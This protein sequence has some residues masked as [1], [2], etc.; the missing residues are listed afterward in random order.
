MSATAVRQLLEIR[1]GR[2]HR[3][4][5]LTES[6]YRIGR[7]E[8]NEVCLRA[9]RV[10]RFHARL[11]WTGVSYEVFDLN[12]SNNVRVNGERV[13][14]RLLR[15][16]DLLELSDMVEFLYIQEG[17]PEEHTQRLLA[18]FLEGLDIRH[19]TSIEA[20]GRSITESEEL[21]PTLEKI[22]RAVMQTVEADR[23]FVALV[24]DEGH[25]RFAEA[26]TIGIDLSR[27]EEPGDDPA[28]SHTTVERALAERDVYVIERDPTVESDSEGAEFP[29]S[30]LKLDLRRAVAS[31]LL[32]GESLVGVLYLDA[33][34]IGTTFG[35]LERRVF[36]IL[37]DQA[38]IA[39]CSSGIFLD[40]VRTK[41]GLEKSVAEHS[42]RIVEA[43]EMYGI[44][45]KH[46]AQGIFIAQGEE[47]LFANEAL[48]SLLG[49]EV[50]AVEDI[51]GRIDAEQ[52]SMVR[53]TLYG[54]GTDH[55]G[56]DV[57]VELRLEPPGRDGENGDKRWIEL[58]V[59]PVSLRGRSALQGTMIDITERRML[60]ERLFHTQRMEALG[61]L[62]GGIAHEFNNLLMMIQGSADI[63][64]HGMA[65]TDD[66]ELLHEIQK[67]CGR[68]KDLTARLLI[69]GRRKLGVRRPT[70]LKACI[71]ETVAL[72]ERTAPKSVL[73]SAKSCKEQVV[74]EV[75]RGRICQSLLNLG[76]NA[77]D[78]MEPGGCL[79]FEVSVGPLP[80]QVMRRFPRLSHGDYAR[81]VVRDTGAGMD[82]RTLGQVFDPFFT[83][84]GP[85]RGTGL[86]LAMVY[87]AM[88][89]C[90]GA[91]EVDSAMGTGTAVTLY[92]PL[93]KE[94]EFDEARAVKV[95]Q[96][97]GSE[98]IL[99]VD[100]EPMVRRTVRGLLSA[101]NY[102]VESA[103]SGAEA[104]QRLD[105]SGEAFDVVVLDVSMPD[106]DG[107]ECM[108][109]MRKKLPSV[110]ILLMSGH[111]LSLDT[112]NAAGA[113]VPEFLLK[114]FD[115]KTLLRSVRTLLRR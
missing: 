47:V 27:A 9:K 103:A 61:T 102:R 79:E 8:E 29:S 59:Q 44:L 1:D 95:P 22:L 57:R 52:Q 100:D 94:Q 114:P 40:L 89:D 7:D 39:I 6:T 81:V 63:L 37:S 109:L 3:R 72:L 31:P 101:H 46:S 104:L 56:A 28:F 88:R 38:A 55:L 68:G 78:A 42:A 93:V 110:R 11:E 2:I 97:G 113:E 5:Q 96:D 80:E 26:V 98:R 70:P 24:D 83:T 92:F 19:L 48:V 34:T 58:F 107:I 106:M 45:S 15:S 33:Q 75:D 65:S 35:E 14:R 71:E 50:S 74:V 4:I 51:V 77:L 10:S 82:E 91:V 76:L 32:V 87:A 20:I 41:Q 99:V 43:E 66:R 36:R 67:A 21:K 23:G 86:G 16:G 64:A 85:D 90:G 12:S 62:A 18:R 60:H 115:K 25:V 84:K 73:V 111:P 108:R 30:V 13:S 105:E 69:L 54:T 17:A 53:R 49:R 112:E